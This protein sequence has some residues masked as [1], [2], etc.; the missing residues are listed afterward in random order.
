MK[1]RTKDEKETFEL[2][3]K[4]G[5]NIPGSVCVALI[6]DLGAGKTA[7]TKG[8]AAGLGFSDNI[9][10][11]TFVV[12]KT[13]ENKKARAHTLC[14]IDAYRLT[15]GDDLRAIGV[16]EY[17][18][19]DQTVVIIEWADLVADI[20]PADAIVMHFKRISGNSREIEI[21]PD[22]LFLL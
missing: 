1:I 15:S 8:I 9:N 10:S 12:M 3:V 5:Q 2:G 19:D 6:G 4:I 18:T 22:L 21:K 17:L 20:V 13:Y 14:H 7:M 11:P 16:E